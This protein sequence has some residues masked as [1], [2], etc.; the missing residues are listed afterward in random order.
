MS[1]DPL[2]LFRA[3]VEALERENWHRIAAL[4]DAESLAAF[5]RDLLDSI[6]P[7]PGGPLK[8][9]AT[10]LMKA[11]PNVPRAV[12][13]YMVSRFRESL[14]PKRRL[15][16]EIPGAESREALEKMTPA[17]VY[18]LWLEGRSVRRQLDREVDR[19]HMSRATANEL[20]ADGSRRME[21][22]P[23]GFVTE[24]AETAHVVYRS[25]INGRRLQTATAHRQANGDWLLVADRELL[26]MHQ[27][28]L[29]SDGG[30]DEAPEL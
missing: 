6:A 17:E 23:L 10:E 18:A 8:L 29:T 1:S 24:G 16:E 3:A 26:M 25:S 7:P 28:R 19:K 11:S 22:T 14:D 21:F 12:A 30:E 2:S 20:L 5:K 4:C 13:E 27:V 15:K 9:S